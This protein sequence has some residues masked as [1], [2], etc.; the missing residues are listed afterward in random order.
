[1]A[2]REVSVV[3]VKGALRRWLKGEG[4]RP[5]AKGV[6]VDRKTTPRPALVDPQGGPMTGNRGGPMP[7][8]KPAAATW[9]HVAGKRHPIATRRA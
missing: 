2:F 1:M 6:G 5:I 7:L 8:A 9:S 4:E 3:Q